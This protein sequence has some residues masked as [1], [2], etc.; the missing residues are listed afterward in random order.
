MLCMYNSTDFTPS[1]VPSRS[2]VCMIRLFES[3]PRSIALLYLFGNGKERS[4]RPILPSSGICLYTVAMLR[5][6]ITATRAIACVY[7]AK[8]VRTLVLPFITVALLVSVAAGWLTAHSLWWVLLDLVLFTAI[9]LGILLLVTAT[10]TM[11]ILTPPLTK[12]QR[13]EVVAFIEKLQRVAEALGLPLFWV[14]YRLLRDVLWPGRTN[15]VI[16]M[17]QDSIS[18]YGDFTRLQKI[19]V[20]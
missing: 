3:I 14:L 16:E 20:N 5:P 9:I 17:T 6:A 18:L 2:K 13:S 12:N 19:F 11:A 10:M 1:N 15:F 7:M 8:I 4:K